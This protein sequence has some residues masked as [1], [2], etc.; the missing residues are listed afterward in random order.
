MFFSTSAGIVRQFFEKKDQIFNFFLRQKKSSRDLLQDSD[1][2]LTLFYFFQ[3]VACQKRNP[4]FF[5]K[6]KAKD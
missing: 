2:H 6:K 3:K 5:L 1:L 4:T